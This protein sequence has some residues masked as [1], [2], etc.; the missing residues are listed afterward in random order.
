MGSPLEEVRSAWRKTVSAIKDGP[1]NVSLWEALEACTPL[2]FEDGRLYLGLKAGELHRST[3]L[4]AVQTKLAIQSYFAGFIGAGAA[5]AVFFEGSD[6]EAFLRERA[7][8]TAR[9]SAEEEGRRLREQSA[10]SLRGWDWLSTELQRIYNAVPEK[11]LPWNLVEY[12]KQALQLTVQVENELREAGK[13]DRELARGLARTLHKIAGHVEM[14]LLWVTMEY[15][16]LQ[17]KI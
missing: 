1:V 2:A 6:E 15:M 7:R 10:A 14:P 3:T 8:E 12:L 17:G 13:D 16:K 9:T 4:S 11:S 5:T